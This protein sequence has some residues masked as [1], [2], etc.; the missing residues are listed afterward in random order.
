MLKNWLKFQK[1]WDKIFVVMQIDLIRQLWLQKILDK[2]KLG[3]IVTVS[4]DEMV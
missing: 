4:V 3:K 1:K 2:D